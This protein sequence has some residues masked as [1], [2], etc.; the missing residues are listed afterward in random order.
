MNQIYIR[1]ILPGEAAALQSVAKATFIDTYAR[2]N[3]PENMQQ[4]LEKGF[5]LDRLTAELANPQIAY[6]WGVVD[7]ERAGYLKLNHGAAQSEPDFPDGM[8]IERIYVKAAF[9]GRKL[10]RHFLEHAVNYAKEG[11]FH[12]LWLGVW[13]KNQAALQFYQHLGFVACG[14]H[15]F[16]L[17]TEVQTDILMRWE[18]EGTGW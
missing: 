10:G 15:E 5:A 8:E 6:F 1:P 18:N 4:Y 17:G 3:T 11:G 12:P 16:V 14:T 7:G 9:K 2:H 13:E